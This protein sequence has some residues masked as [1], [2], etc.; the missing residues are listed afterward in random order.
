MTKLVEFE[1]IAGGSGLRIT[2]TADGKVTTSEWF[3]AQEDAEKVFAELIEYQLCNGWH[4]IAPEEIGALTDATI[5]TDDVE[6]DEH[7][8]MVRCGR[9]YSNINYYQIESD[10][11][12]L[13]RNG[14]LIWTGAE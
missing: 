11:E 2:P 10:V 5:I 14:E 1:K 9:V 6:R 4:R 8:K 7:G 12:R 3:F 13:L